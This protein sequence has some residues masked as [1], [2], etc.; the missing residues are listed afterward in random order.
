MVRR[1]FIPGLLTAALLLAAGAVA[2]TGSSRVTAPRL[3]RSLPTVFAHLYATQA[4]LQGTPIISSDTLNPRAQCRRIGANAAIDGPGGDWA[5]LMSWQDPGLP[6]PPEGWGR[7]EL[8]VRSNGCYTATGPSRLI[9]LPTITDTHGEDVT[10]PLSEFDACFDP[11]ADNTP[12]GVTFSALLLVTS[13][14]LSPVNGTIKPEVLC[15]LGVGRCTGTAT[16]SVNGAEVSQARYDFVEGIGGT[17]NL[18][19]PPSVEEVTLTFHATEGRTP[20]TP[21]TL[22]VLRR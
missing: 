13:T 6:M 2:A 7:F 14:T 3:E 9:G 19:A 10:N 18:A 20:A 12:T 11:D 17:L 21:V 22:P 8:N 1:F 4:R 16:V 15:T 5:C